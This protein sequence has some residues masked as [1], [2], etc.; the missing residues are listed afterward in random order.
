LRIPMR[1]GRRGDTRSVY[2]VIPIQFRPGI[3]GRR[4]GINGRAWNRSWANLRCG[5]RKY[6]PWCTGSSAN[7]NGKKPNPNTTFPF[8]LQRSYMPQLQTFSCNK[9]AAQE[10]PY[11]DGIY[12]DIFRLAIPTSPS[13]PE[14]KSQIAA[15]IGT[16]LTESR[17]SSIETMSFKEL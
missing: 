6:A 11:R 17:T 14:P 15:G 5:D 8:G 3:T 4:S 16:W 12:Y 7:R 1:S 9:K 13:R 10:P 2:G